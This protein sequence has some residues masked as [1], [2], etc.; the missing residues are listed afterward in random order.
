MP[1]AAWQVH[2]RHTAF[3]TTWRAGRSRR[4][5][6]AHLKISHPEV[7]AA[8]GVD[9]EQRWDQLPRERRSKEDVS[10]GCRRARR[11]RA[12]AFGSGSFS[13]DRTA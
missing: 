4:P 3:V 11:V 10:R 9:F 13:H 2:A 12:A 1:E 5:E 8:F 7:V 6:L